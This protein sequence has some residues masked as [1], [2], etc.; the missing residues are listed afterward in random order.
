MLII[1]V[2]LDIPI[3]KDREIEKG[4][5]PHSLDQDWRLGYYLL[6]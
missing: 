3:N 5:K 4:T 2:S 6:C 1:T